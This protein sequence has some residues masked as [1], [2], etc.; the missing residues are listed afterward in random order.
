MAVHA[1]TSDQVVQVSY[2][3]GMQNGDWQVNVSEMARAIKEA[4]AASSADI[5]LAERAQARVVQ[6][7][8]V[9]A[10]Q[11]IQQVWVDNFE[12]A[13]LMD[14]LGRERRERDRR[15]LRR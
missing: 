9:G 11:G 10:V 2:E 6:A 12:D 15:D 5:A 8:S 13:D 4:Q 3:E 14:V 1:H 7:T